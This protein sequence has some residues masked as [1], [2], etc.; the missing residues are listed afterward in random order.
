MTSL[1][2]WSGRNGSTFLGMIYQNADQKS[3]MAHE[4]DET[5]VPDE[6]RKVDPLRRRTHA[7]LHHLGEREQRGQLREVASLPTTRRL[8]I[9]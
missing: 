9:V 4:D 5:L 6:L 7:R 3:H 2:E 8:R 1:T